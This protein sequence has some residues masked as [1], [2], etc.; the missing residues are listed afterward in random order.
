MIKLFS[1]KKVLKF[2]R[3]YPPF[4]GAGVSVD[5]MNND[6][7]EI[8]VKMSLTRLNKNYL[9]VHFGGSL[10]SMCDPFYM[11]MLLHHLRDEHIVWD[12]AANI[13][14]IKPGK[15]EVKAH[16]KITKELIEDIKQ[17]TLNEFSVKPKLEV[18]IKDLDGDVVA[19]VI[20][21]LYIRRKDAKERFSQS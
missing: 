7:T 10:Y 19:R 5:F 6:L 17:K 9:G 3:F 11:F 15:S 4:L 20:K 1:P 16:F 2:I 21:T 12:Q 13:E 8:I 14:F 18:Q